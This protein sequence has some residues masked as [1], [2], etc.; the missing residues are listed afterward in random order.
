MA[1]PPLAPPP[2][3]PPPLA[4]PPLAPAA[5][6]EPLPAGWEAVD[7]DLGR[8]YYWNVDTDEVLWT[9]PTAATHPPPPPS[10]TD[11]SAPAMAMAPAAIEAAPEIVKGSSGGGV[12]PIARAGSVKGNADFFTK[13]IAEANAPAAF[14]LRPPLQSARSRR[15]PKSSRTPRRARRRRTSPKRRRLLIR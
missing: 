3:A 1:P 12:E 9:R 11:A 13:A 7:D 14:R 6:E 8:T 4:P 15:R 5:A 2:L 10:E